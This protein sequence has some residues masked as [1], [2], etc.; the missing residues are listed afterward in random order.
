MDEW[1]SSSPTSRDSRTSCWSGVAP[2][3][4]AGS[5]ARVAFHSDSGWIANGFGCVAR[6]PRSRVARSSAQASAADAL[7]TALAGSEADAAGVAAGDADA[8]WV[9]GAALGA[10]VGTVPLVQAATTT[11]ASSQ[12]KRVRSI[13]SPLEISAFLSTEMPPGS[14]LSRRSSRDRR[15][16]TPVGLM[17]LTLGQPPTTRA[18]RVHHLEAAVEPGV[19]RELVVDEDDRRAVRGP[20]RVER[21]RVVEGGVVADPG[22]AVVLG[23][24]PDVRAIGV[25]DHHVADVAEV[26]R[27]AAE[28]EALAVG[29]PVRVRGMQP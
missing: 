19:R 27:L 26:R 5:D 20:R 29:R 17:L 18:V 7:G 23:Q 11:A 6:T 24:V 10:V 12:A 1:V 16:G 9:A 8:P 14:L 3:R 28:H 21:L 2:A 22:D 25:R 4:S 15:G 13:G